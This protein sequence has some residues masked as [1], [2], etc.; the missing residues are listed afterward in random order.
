MSSKYQ[1]LFGSDGHRKRV[2]FNHW[3]R[4]P[5]G[6]ILTYDNAVVGKLAP[7]DLQLWGE[8]LDNF[9]TTVRVPHNKGNEY[10]N[11]HSITYTTSSKMLGWCEEHNEHYGLAADDMREARKEGNP[12][13]IEPYDIVKLIRQ[14]EKA[15]FKNALEPSLQLVPSP[16]YPMP[17]PRV[18]FSSDTAKWPKPP[19]LEKLLPLSSLPKTLIVHDPWDAVDAELQSRRHTWKQPMNGSKALRYRLQLSKAGE[20][21][22]K[23]EIKAVEGK[24]EADRKILETFLADP[25]TRNQMP[26]NGLIILAQDEEGNDVDTAIFCLLSAPPAVD[27]NEPAHLRIAPSH[28]LGSGHHS[29]LYDSEYE[30][31]RGLLVPPR[32]CESCVFETA[33]RILEED[34]TISHVIKDPASGDDVQ[35]YRCTPERLLQMWSPYKGPF[36]VVPVDV[37]YFKPFD[38]PCKHFASTPEEMRMPP[39]ATVRVAAKLSS[40]GDNH[41]KAEAQNY[42]GFPLFFFQ[43]WSGFVIPQGNSFPVPVGAITPQYYGYYVFDTAIDEDDPIAEGPLPEVEDEEGEDKVPYR[44]A[45]LLMELCG[46]P[47]DAKELSLDDSAG[48]MHHSIYQRNIVRKPGPIHAS[49]EERLANSKKYGGKGDDWNFRI[50]D[51]GRSCNNRDKEHPCY[52]ESYARDTW[53]ERGKLWKWIT[54]NLPPEY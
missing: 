49:P 43:H 25:H 10:I 46:E 23:E 32:F 31:P 24:K 42:E 4:D 1:P 7:G 3:P 20:M 34:D 36:R 18:P 44:S 2:I 12:K 30:V 27:P 40:E 11:G 26:E 21:R 13:V 39:T 29:V 8:T 52:D 50:I 22:V 6:D 33:V 28:Y 14:H 47:I 41:L 45:I 16:R 15:A 35:F 5:D 54:L 17:W 19:M 37:D 48:W 9:H 53:G 38:E 51:F